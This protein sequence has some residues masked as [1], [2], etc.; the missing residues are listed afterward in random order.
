LGNP[1]LGKERMELYFDSKTIVMDDY[2]TLQGFG[3]PLA[4]NET[5]NAVDKGHEYLIG[6]F[7]E[8][9]K[10]DN[11]EPLINFE[12][13]YNVAKLTLVIDQLACAGGGTKELT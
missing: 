7:F 5:C 11:Y 8:R 2:K 3:L 9:I 4:F 10:S 13:L 6:Q 12:R 1:G